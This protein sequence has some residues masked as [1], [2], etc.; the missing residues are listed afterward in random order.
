M[1]VWHLAQ[2][3]RLDR[4]TGLCNDCVARKQKG[5]L[6]NLCLD[7]ARI[8]LALSLS[9]LIVFRSVGD[10]GKEHYDERYGKHCVA[11]ICAFL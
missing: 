9:V 10:T 7:R 3:L 8:V 4:Q 2:D 11:C 1:L 5:L 6:S